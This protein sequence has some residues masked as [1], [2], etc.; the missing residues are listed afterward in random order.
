MQSQRLVRINELLKRE[1]ADILYREM[2]GTDFDFAAVTI[3]RVEISPN[4]RQARVAVSVRGDDRHAEAALRALR[5][6]RAHIQNL[7]HKDV[8]LKYTP[9]LQF[10]RDAS[11]EQGDH[12]LHLI[13]E[14]ESRGDIDAAAGPPPAAEDV[15]PAGAGGEEEDTHAPA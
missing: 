3:T 10:E 5:R 7:V 4:L 9:V 6:H 13:S 15:P 11:I 14:M 1:I 8:I 12:V 2:A